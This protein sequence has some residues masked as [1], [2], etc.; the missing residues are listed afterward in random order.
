MSDSAVSASAKG[1]SFLILLQV[2]SRALTF[3]LNQILL[4][5]LS[6]ELLGVSV[7]LELY[8]ISVLY[9]S[10]ESLRVALQRRADGVQVVVNL[11]YLALAVG[12]PL[13][14]L[15]AELYL[16]T[17]VPRVP[18]LLQ[19][20]RIYGAASL[21]ELLAEPAFVAAQQKMLYKVRAF[22]EAAA[23]ILKTF[24]MV[25]IVYWAN[26]S[27]KDL[28][29]LPFAAGQFAY[30]GTLL[31]VYATQM[32]LVA[33]SEGFSLLPRSVVPNK[34]ERFWLGLFS[35]PLLNLTLSLTVQSSIKY[36]LTQGDS[37]L[38]A[39]LASL[40]D[41]GAYALS[42]NYGGLIAR[43]LFQPIEE[44]SRNLFAKLCASATAPVQESDI[45]SQTKPSQ[46]GLK[47]ASTTLR[48]ILKFYS[49]ISLAA[50]S[51]GPRT[52]PLLLKLVA[53]SKWADTGAGDVLGVY[54]YYIPLLAINGVTEAFVAAV[55]NNKELYA[56]SVWMGAFFAGF[57]GSAY[58]FLRILEMGAKG[59]VYAN[60]VNM[61]LRIVFNLSFISGFFARNGQAFELLELLPTGFS[62]AITAVA[63]LDTGVMPGMLS[64]YGM[65]GDL[66]R[67]GGVASLF[68]LAL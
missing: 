57:A 58:L 35:R 9:F 26:R 24:V 43:M 30:A 61:A 59:L 21:V 22:S 31:L 1:A 10:R 8:C 20:L 45:K 44:A 60:C 6:P 54:C 15:L 32:A 17:E 46:D 65:L 40:Q 13:S 16:R 5:F 3:A 19:A 28:G 12:V 18:Y 33:R 4:R 38:I 49:L 52:A 23:T 50:F 25:G 2:G 11:A 63:A 14:Y 39:S 48:D 53:G 51:L 55:A 36:V 7:Q 64:R 66:V 67:A 37:I 34:T 29:V 56:Q 42:S 62:I 47:R 68:A 41:Q 27:G